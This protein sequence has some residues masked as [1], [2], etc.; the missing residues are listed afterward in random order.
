MPVFRPDIL[1]DT[2]AEIMLEDNRQILEEKPSAAIS[3]DPTRKVYK[4]AM[5]ITFLVTNISSL[6]VDIL[7]QV[8]LL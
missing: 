2:S 3:E 4:L 1:Q 6:L 8:L 7:T 5:T